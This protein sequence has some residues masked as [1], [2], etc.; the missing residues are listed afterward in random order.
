[1]SASKSPSVK[2]STMPLIKKIPINTSRLLWLMLVLNMVHV[3]FMKEN[4]LATTAVDCGIS[5]ANSYNLETD[6]KQALMSSS[7]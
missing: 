2:D 5:R 7:S 4:P 6:G 3:S 1:M